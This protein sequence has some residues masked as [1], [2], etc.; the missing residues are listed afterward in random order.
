MLGLIRLER[1]EHSNSHLHS[2]LET[3]CYA[4]GLV[5]T[6]KGTK[7]AEE[8]WF[9][10]RYHNSLDLPVLHYSE[11]RYPYLQSVSL[12]QPTEGTGDWAIIASN[13]SYPTCQARRGGRGEEIHLFIPPHLLCQGRVEWAALWSHWIISLLAAINSLVVLSTSQPLGWE[14]VL[15]APKA[16]ARRALDSLTHADAC[17]Y[18]HTR[19]G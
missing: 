15:S 19:E 3:D 6:V 14:S 11:G 9:R 12:W 10:F 7:Q 4:V 1:C 18:T 13:R 17:T 5:S 16:C 8:Y 2:S